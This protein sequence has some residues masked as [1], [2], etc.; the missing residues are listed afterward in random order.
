MERRILVYKLS[1]KYGGTESFLINY[2]RVISENIPVRFD[3]LTEAEPEEAAYAGDVK[4][5]GGRVYKI[6]DRHK[7]PIRNF[8]WIRNFLKEHPEYDTL[9]FCAMSAPIVISILGCVGMGRRIVVHSH[10]GGVKA[11]G[12]HKLCRILL[13]RLA[14]SKLACSERAARFMFGNKEFEKKM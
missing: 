5:L 2:N 10:N 7:H 8:F 11:V 12:R 1:E 9:Y 6:V 14:D 13:N 3:Y 4:K